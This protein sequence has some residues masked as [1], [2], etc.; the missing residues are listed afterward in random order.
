MS[1]LEEFSE[2]IEGMTEDELEELFAEARALDENRSTADKVAEFYHVNFV[3]PFG[4]QADEVFRV[5]LGRAIKENARDKQIVPEKFGEL[6]RVFKGLKELFGKDIDV[7][8]R[9]AF[10]AGSITV[11]VSE[12]T[13]DGA[14]SKK[15]KAVLEKCNTFEV[16]PLVSGKVDI[17]VTIKGLFEKIE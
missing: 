11:K 5:V 8:L 6:V 14:A 10:S 12:V 16:T 3:E 13:L 7:K 17:G 4:D 9:P 2:L 1:E 15:L